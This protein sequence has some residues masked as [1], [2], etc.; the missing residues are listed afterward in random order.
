MLFA[1]CEKQIFLVQDIQRHV[2]HPP[3]P[4][5][6]NEETTFFPIEKCEVILLEHWFRWPCFNEDAFDELHDIRP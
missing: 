2:I 5:S 1:Y 4:Y 6:Q 3:L